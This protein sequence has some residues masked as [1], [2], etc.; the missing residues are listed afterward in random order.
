MKMSGGTS[1]TAYCFEMGDKRRQSVLR[2]LGVNVREKKRLGDYVQ[3]QYD[4]L[5]KKQP[6]LKTSVEE[7]Y[8]RPKRTRRS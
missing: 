7:E 8:E 2:A 1:H 3:Q 5:M 4:R 6:L